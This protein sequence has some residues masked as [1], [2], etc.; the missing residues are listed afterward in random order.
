MADL[1]KILAKPGNN[2]CDLRKRKDPTIPE[3]GRVYLI[4][5]QSVR[6]ISASTPFRER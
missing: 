3:N 1:S 5:V 6:T 2:P 4:V